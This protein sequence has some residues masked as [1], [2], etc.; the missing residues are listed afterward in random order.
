MP[1]AG[2]VDHS[3]F[4]SHANSSA[5][6]IP[7]PLTPTFS[8]RGHSR[9]SSSTSSIDA[10]LAVPV[11]ESPSSPT[12]RVSGAGKRPL[13]DVQEEPQEAHDREEDEDIDTDMEK[14]SDEL[15]DCFCE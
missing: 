15:Y 5:S 3:S 6:S 14:E 2:A 9:Y 1:E 13:P 4:Y 11:M 7:S 10:S 8:A 12:F